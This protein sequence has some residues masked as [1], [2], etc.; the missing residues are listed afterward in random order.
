[1][2]F[3]EQLLGQDGKQFQMNN[4]WVPI[5][6]EKLIQVRPNTVSGWPANQMSRADYQEFH[7]PGRDY[8]NEMLLHYHGP[9]QD[10]RLMGQTVQIGEHSNFGG[11]LANR[12]SVI[13]HIAGSYT[14]AQHYE[15]NGL[16]NNTLSNGL[17]NNTLELLLNRNA[18]NIATA[19][20]NLDTS[21]NMAARNPLLPKLYPQTS[22]DVS[23]SYAA[24]DIG[25][26]EANRLLIPNRISEF[27][28]CNTD[29]L[30]NNDIHCSVSNQL[31]GIF[32]NAS[33]GDTYPEHY[34]NYV[35]TSEADAT[36]SFTNSLQSIPK[37]MDQHKFVENQFAHFREL[38][39]DLDN[40]AI[41]ESS[42]HE[43]DFVPCTENEIQEY[44]EGLLQQIVDS[45]SAI[46]STTRG[47]QK[48]SVSNICDKG[49]N[50]I[51]DLNKTPEQKVT[52]RRKHR[53][54]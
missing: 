32:S 26:R 25:Y 50:E 9:Y 44:S 10:P 46:I 20:R 3:G 38:S 17:N 37:T 47:D 51:L 16:N 22:S 23:Y 34:L 52:R 6:P 21:I 7:I 28:G 30:L 24:S 54:K 12:N 40:H 41:A 1:M 5:T 2:N 18:T 27:S 29:S 15:S 35:P 53:P 8:V 4:T 31:K 36:T 33:Y 13:N 48:G 39:R 19:N 49:S 45:S 11:N 42:S 43:K 14:Q